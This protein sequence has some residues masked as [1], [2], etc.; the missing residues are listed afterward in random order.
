MNG[1]ALHCLVPA[2]NTACRPV[3]QSCTSAE[4][5]RLCS[6]LHVITSRTQCPASG[7][8]LWHHAEAGNSQGVLAAGQHTGAGVR[9]AAS[10][11]TRSANTTAPHKTSLTTQRQRIVTGTLAHH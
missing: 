1:A 11:A 10:D 2:C 5:W 4:T 6:A 3:R 8:A 7:A 9:G